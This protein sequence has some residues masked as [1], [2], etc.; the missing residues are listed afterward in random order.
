[1]LDIFPWEADSLVP[2]F[3][4][5]VNKW[6]L[7]KPTIENSISFHLQCHGSWNQDLHFV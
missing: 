4:T 2:R 7:V 6:V 5:E 3:A 1:M